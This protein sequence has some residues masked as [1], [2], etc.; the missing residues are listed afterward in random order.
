MPKK[1]AFPKLI[2]ISK[3]TYFLKNIRRHWNDGIYFV[4]IYARRYIHLFVYNKCSSINFFEKVSNQAVTI[5]IS[6]EEI[7]KMKEKEEE[8]GE[9][10]STSSK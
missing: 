7:M 5:N 1:Y 8:A 2:Y 4:S 9:K 6:L 10:S 3:F